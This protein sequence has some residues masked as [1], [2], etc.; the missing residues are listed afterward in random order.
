MTDR[1]RC[2][3]VLTYTWRCPSCKT[4]QAEQQRHA[5]GKCFTCVDQEGIFEAWQRSLKRQR[6]LRD[7]GVGR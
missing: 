2:L 4:M 5:S 1:E 6:E 3:E 7:A